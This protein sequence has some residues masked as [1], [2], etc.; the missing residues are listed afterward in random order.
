MKA[1]LTDSMPEFTRCLAEKMLTYSLGRGV[2]SY[3]RLRR[4]EI[5][6]RQTAADEYRLQALILGIVTA[7]RSSSGAA[8]G[9]RQG[10]QEDAPGQ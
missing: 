10:S 1:L 6:S 8:S 9:S 4:A 7:R 2:E 3:D 5:W